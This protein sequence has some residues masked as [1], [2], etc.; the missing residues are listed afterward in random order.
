MRVNKQS[1][2]DLATA[3]HPKYLKASR[4][5]KGRLLDDFVEVTGY[6]RNYA[7]HLLLHGLHDPRIPKE[8]GRADARTST[9]T[10]RHA[11]GRPHV[12]GPVVLQALCVAA[13]ATGWICG[14]RL[15]GVLPELVDALEQE[16]AISLFASE[17]EALLNMS[18]ATIDR[19]LA[20]QRAQHKPKGMCTTKPG[21]L[22][23][24]QV[25]IRTYTP[26]DQQQPGFL[27][28][29]LV[30]HCGESTAGIY[31]CTL[32]CV[33]V[34]TGWTECVAVANKGQ[35]AVFAALQ[36]V[37][38]RLPFPLLGIDS[39]NGAEFINDQL[40]RY[41]QAEKIT[42]TRCRPYRKNDQA[43]VE[44]KNGS[45]VR[46]LVG[47]DRYTTPA[48]LVQLGRVYELTRLHVN[49]YLPVMK[50]VGK[51][52]EG[53]KVKKRYDTP[54]TPYQRALKAGVLSSEAQA[55]FQSQLRVAAPGPL[56]LRHQLLAALDKLWTLSATSSYEATIAL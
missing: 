19:K 33:D 2:Q 7:K 38:V 24:S 5:E 56:A 35:Q 16:G 21:T 32:N 55:H 29:D 30:A 15:V 6:H 53:A 52:R 48:A 50:L 11:G 39:D 14:K 27:E 51:Q 23:R 49:A 17:R 22:L 45:V 9:R 41:C 1:K 42:F 44:Q 34:A 26:W 40:V 28:V 37:R 18:A 20:P 4:K 13:Q 10:R 43:H 12:Y 31:L 54:T 47:Y 36:A 46:Q 8:T 25:P 3:L